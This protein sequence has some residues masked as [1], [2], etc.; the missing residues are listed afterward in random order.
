MGQRTFIFTWKDNSY[1]AFERHNTISISKS[2]G[3]IGYDA[4]AATDLFCKTFGNLKKVSI[5]SIQ[6]ID[7]NGKAIGEPI[8]PQEENSII[9]TKK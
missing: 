6:E 3:E 9:P 5:I 2:T 1:N 7:K 4:K 8:T